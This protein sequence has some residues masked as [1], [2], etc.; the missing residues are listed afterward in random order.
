MNKYYCAIDIGASSGRVILFWIEN[1]KLVCEEVH[2][3]PNQIAQNNNYLVWKHDALFNEVLF[4]LKKC[5]EINKIPYSI[6]IDTWGVDFVLLDDS[7]EIIGETICYRDDHVNGM[8]QE[9]N[10]IISEYELYQRTGIQKLSFNTIYQLIAIKNQQPEWLRQASKFL[11]I[12]DYFN[13]RLT[14][15]FSCEYTN[16][17]TTQLLDVH[18]RDWDLELLEKLGL[19][20]HIFPI[21]NQPGFILGEISDEIQSQ[22]GYC[23]KV[24]LT[25]SHDTG[26]AVVAVPMRSNEDTVYISSGTWSL[27]GLELNEPMLDQKSFMSNFTNEGGYN[28]TIRFLK[29]IMGLWLIQSLVIEF[30]DK[31]TYSELNFGAEHETINSIIDCNDSSFLAPKSMKSAIALY[32]EQ[33]NQQIPRT[34]FEYARVV[35]RSL[36]FS[37]K[38][39]ILEFEDITNKKINTIYIV[40]GGS[41]ADYLCQLIANCTSRKVIA[42]LSEGTAYGNAIVQMIAN[43]D[44]D[45]LEKARECL[46]N[47]FIERT[48]L[49]KGEN[50]DTL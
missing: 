4:G 15:Q 28:H 1:K 23:S 7:N 36:A 47:S 13:Y 3:F 25:A 8:D 5:K 20:T 26:S 43:Y 21:I 45:S 48:Y 16:A 27:I 12:P 42:G 22:L 46:S 18:T 50:N 24:V 19:P 49:P 34:P 10:K 11:M 2:R 6:S 29:N 32:C 14:N 33:T 39:T 30:K 35:Y 9:V 41:Q 38:K 37:Y 44:F 40:G 17:S 31:Y